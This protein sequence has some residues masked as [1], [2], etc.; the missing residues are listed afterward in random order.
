MLAA[1]LLWDNGKWLKVHFCFAGLDFQT[2]NVLRLEGLFLAAGWQASV[3]LPPLGG[4]QRAS[5][6][7][8]VLR[9]ALWSFARTGRH[10]LSGAAQKGW[11]RQIVHRRFYQHCGC[12]S[13]K[14]QV[15]KNIQMFIHTQRTI[16]Y[17]IYATYT[18]DIQDMSLK[19]C[20][21]IRTRCTNSQKSAITSINLIR[22]QGG[23][24]PVTKIKPRH[25]CHPLSQE[26]DISA[27]D[28]TIQWLQVPWLPAVFSFVS[29]WGP[30]VRS[31]F[32]CPTRPSRCLRH[33]GRGQGPE[34]C[35]VSD[36]ST[37]QTCCP[38][39]DIAKKSPPQKRRG[40]KAIMAS[41]GKRFFVHV[42]H[43]SKSITLR[44]KE[45]QRGP[46]FLSSSSVCR[47]CCGLYFLLV[48][49][50]S[51]TLTFAGRPR[52]EEIPSV[53][54]SWLTISIM[55][56]KR[57][58]I[59]TDCT[60]SCCLCPGHATSRKG[61]QESG[62]EHVFNKHPSTRRHLWQSNWWCIKMDLDC[63][64]TRLGVLPPMAWY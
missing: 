10:W 31:P 28:L 29:T 8:F 26:A 16:W 6:H 45:N 46:G 43:V 17:L 4:R 56:P 21:Q 15:V 42:S 57:Q 1:S 12:L 55:V 2:H 49:K 36:P 38:S 18:W 11:A 44:M 20:M 48:F 62:A 54:A 25:P 64:T 23:E 58:I 24:R 47:S 52:S 7:V 32:R 9:I 19:L 27:A 13:D 51:F 3:T 50:G 35:P 34:K 61:Q 60:R 53:Q 59:E 5:A 39:Q 33:H 30:S 41:Y 63:A 40:E 22:S 14:R 37:F